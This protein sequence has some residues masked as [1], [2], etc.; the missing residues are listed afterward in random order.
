MTEGDKSAYWRGESKTFTSTK[1]DP[2]DIALKAVSAVYWQWF[3]GI[4]KPEVVESF[5]QSLKAALGDYV[6]I[7]RG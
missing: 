1:D 3:R 6:D 7:G 5:C 2:R 4:G